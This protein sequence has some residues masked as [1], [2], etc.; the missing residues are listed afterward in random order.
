MINRLPTKILHNKL[1]WEC[2]SHLAP[3]YH[4]LRTF[5]CLCF[6]WLRPYN[7]NK[8]EFRS[9]L[10]VFLKY[11]INHLGYKCLDIDNGRIFLSRHVV[12]NDYIFLF[13]SLP[14]SPTATP[15]SNGPMFNLR[16]NS[17]RSCLPNSPLPSPGPYVSQFV[18]PRPP[19]KIVVSNF[20]LPSNAFLLL[21]VPSPTAAEC[22]HGSDPPLQPI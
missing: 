5:G 9:Q 18:G 11:N 4:F 7:K 8:L 15:E 22:P 6:P 2:L 20:S 3:D 19:P 10:C 1:P 12:F 17:V 13:K 21:S 16:K 14:L